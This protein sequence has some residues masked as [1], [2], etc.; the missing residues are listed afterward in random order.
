MSKRQERLR[1]KKKR[2]MHFLIHKWRRII[3]D[4]VPRRERRDNTLEGI[5]P[6]L[7][8]H[9]IIPAQPVLCH[10]GYRRKVINP[11]TIMQRVAARWKRRYRLK[12]H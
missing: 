11:P 6:L 9:N 1:I 8:L 3:D 4:I 7:Q 2:R 10:E 5:L 12:K